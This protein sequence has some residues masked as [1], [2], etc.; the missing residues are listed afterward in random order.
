[1][2]LL[3]LFLAIYVFLLVL[4]PS[5]SL[6]GINVKIICF[7]LLFPVAVQVSFAR[8]QMTSRRVMILLSIPAVFLLWTFASRLYGFDPS[9][10]FA[11]YKDL[12]VTIVTCWIG[13]VLCD[14][15]REDAIF[16][17][18]WVLFAEVATSSLKV[19]L[20]TYAYVRGIPVSQLIDVIHA[21]FGVQLMPFDFESMLGRMQFIS[22]N[23]IPL[24]M[25]AVLCYRQ[26]LRLSNVSALAMLCAFLV[27]DLF[28]FSR[29]L[30]VFTVLAVLCGLVLGK[31]DRF[32]GVVIALL[33]ASV[34]L[35][36]PVLITI[37]SLR[38]STTVATGSDADRIQQVEALRSFFTEA[39]W[40]GH[41]LGSFTHKVVRS[42]T[43][44]YS[45]EAQLLALFG[46]VGIFGVTVLTVLTGSYFRKLRPGHKGKLTYRIGLLVLLLS[47]IVGGFF[48]PSVI[49]SAASVSYVAIFAMT[50]LTAESAHGQSF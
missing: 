5:G 46:Q 18:R 40:F 16:L 33:A 31:K 30:Y 38:F 19:I 4:L 27:S 37:V 49:S 42:E 1:M 28:S 43:A 6:L 2:G 9:D 22:D 12:M 45:Y 11:Q 47:W 29:Y 50:S 32:Y 10:S 15:R 7:L 41:G 21:L 23:L 3:R 26:V 25:F 48:N 44:P 20:L 35:S 36:L 13:K 17:L 39:P 8:Q 14:E 24:C 34:V